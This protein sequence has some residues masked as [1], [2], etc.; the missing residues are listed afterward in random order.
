[1]TTI[2]AFIWGSAIG[3]IIGLLFAPRRGEETRAQLQTRFSQ[4]QGQAQERLGDLRGKATGAIEQGRQGI[5][6]SLGK[7]Q[8]TT[9]RAAE[10][11]KDQVSHTGY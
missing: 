2:R 11:A 3:A 1:M 6:T 4:W 10:S 9:N 8:N 7:A 5:N